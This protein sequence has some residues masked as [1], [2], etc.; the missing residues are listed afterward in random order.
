MDMNAA[1]GANTNN[2]AAKMPLS[3][4]LPSDSDSGGIADNGYGRLTRGVGDDE[5]IGRC[6]FGLGRI[7]AERGC[8]MI[9][10]SCYAAS[11]VRVY[12]CRKYVDIGN[13]ELRSKAN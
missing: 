4:A 2:I 6:I 12:D 11:F 9:P 8:G 10:K 7:M 3:N 5:V 1:K 13:S